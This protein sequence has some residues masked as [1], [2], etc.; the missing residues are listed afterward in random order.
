MITK[1]R[2]NY[3]LVGEKSFRQNE[4]R[5][6]HH[7]SRVVEFLKIIISKHKIIRD[8]RKVNH[9]TILELFEVIKKV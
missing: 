9:L 1:R 4:W 3:T 8:K 7:I 2:T 5:F 6:T